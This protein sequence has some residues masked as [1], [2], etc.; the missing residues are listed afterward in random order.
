MFG[1]ELEEHV[2]MYCLKV[3]SMALSQEMRVWRNG[4]KREKE[5]DENGQQPLERKTMERFPERKNE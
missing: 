4:E 1:A 3:L 5:R 2:Y